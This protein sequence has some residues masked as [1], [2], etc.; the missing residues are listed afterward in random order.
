M[1]Q[2][3]YVSRGRS[4]GT[5]R[6]TTNS[7]KKGKASG[8]SKTMVALAVAVLVTFVGGLYFIAH[9]KPEESPVLPHQN[10]GK[11]NGLPPKPEE[12][13]RYIK[14][15]ENRQLGVTTPTEPSAGGEIQSPVQLTAEQRQLL[16]Q[17]Q[18]DMR[19]QPTQL[20]E[21]PYNDQT[22]VPRSQVAIKPPTQPMQQPPVVTTQPATRAPAVAQTTPVVPKQEI[23][24]QEAPKQQPVKQPEA[25]KAEKTQRWAIQCGSFKTMDP[26]ESVRAQLAFAGIESRITSSGGWNRIM[27]GPYNNRAAADSMLQ[28]LKGAGASNCIPLANGG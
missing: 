6:K 15:L 4:S 24:K 14:E 8:A 26:A 19:R 10:A 3:D 23:P 27:L 17:M 20:S 16:E 12:R 2:R 7:R 5:R 21:V 22:Q 9:N 13:W 28:R 11:G 1:A 18:S 25:P